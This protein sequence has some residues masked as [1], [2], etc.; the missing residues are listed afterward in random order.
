[1]GKGREEIP[2]GGKV[3]LESK[4]WRRDPLIIDLVSRL[5]PS[6]RVRKCLL[7][8]IDINGDVRI[9]IWYWL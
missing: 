4:R 5:F 2:D 1:M 9:E 3:M 8:I 6:T 7:E